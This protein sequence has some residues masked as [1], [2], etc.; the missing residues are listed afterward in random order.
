MHSAVFRL[1]TSNDAQVDIFRDNQ[2]CFKSGTIVCTVQKPESTVRGWVN[3]RAKQKPDNQIPESRGNQLQSSHG[4]LTIGEEKR[5][6]QWI[7]DRQ[8]KEQDPNS[9]EVRELASSLR[10][11]RT[12]CDIECSRHSWASF[13]S[14]HPDLGKELQAAMESAGSEVPAE[15]V[16]SYVAELN[17]T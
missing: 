1:L 17:H 14:R 6:W 5:V 9:L 2:R 11:N 7:V 10:K 3:R 12:H 15:K 4:F 16:R 13:K 8:H